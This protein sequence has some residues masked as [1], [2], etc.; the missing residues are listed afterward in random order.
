[1]MW[2]IGKGARPERQQLKAQRAE[3]GCR[4]LG[5][6]QPRGLGS[7]VSSPAGSGAELRSE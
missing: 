6:G 1:V 3:S 7:A 5:E 2:I 4:V